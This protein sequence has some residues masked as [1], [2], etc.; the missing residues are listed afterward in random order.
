MR[1]SFVYIFGLLCSLL[2]ANGFGHT[3]RGALDNH[4]GP[5]EYGYLFV[6]NQTGDT[7]SYD[8]VELRGDPNA[9]WLDFGS[10]HENGLAAG[11]PLGM[12]FPFYGQYFETIL[13]GV[14]GAL[15][16]LTT[17]RNA[18]SQCIPSLAHDGPVIFPFGS[19]LDVD[20]GGN[21]IGNNST[22]AYRNFDSFTV[23][24]Y[25]SIGRCCNGSTSLK[26]E[27]ILYNSGKIKFQYAQLVGA[28]F[29]AI[30]IQAGSQGPA[31]QYGCGNQGHPP[32]EGLSI[33]FALDNGYAQ[34][35]AGFAGESAGTSVTLSWT[36]PIFDTNGNP[37]TPDSV[38]LY[39]D[40]IE[41]DAQI[42][43]VASGIQS[44]TAQNQ[45][46]GRYVY[47]ARAKAGD[48]VGL[49]AEVWVVIGVPSYQSDFESNSGGWNPG[50]VWEWGAPTNPNAPSPHSGSNVWAVGLN[51]DYTVGLCGEL[52][53]AP[54]LR[55]TSNL[56]RLDFWA[57]WDMGI[58]G[59]FQFDGVNLKS[60]VDD[61]VTWE[62]LSPEF[63]YRGFVL[64]ENLCIGSEAAWGEQSFGWQHIV[65]NVGHLFG[66]TPQFK[67]TFS[68]FGVDAREATG[69]FLDDVTLWGMSPE[70]SGIPATVENLSGTS[71]FFG[72]VSL[73]WD[74]PQ[75]DT[76]GNPLTPDTIL[77]YRGSAIPE[78][79]VANVSA[80]MEI[81]HFENQPFGYMPY[82]ARAKS[83]ANVGAPK[84]CWV[85]IG[86]PSYFSSFESDNGLWEADAEWEWGNPVNWNGPAPHSGENVWGVGLLDSYQ[87]GACGNIT[88]RP[89]RRVAYA[90]ATLELWFWRRIEAYMEGCV[91]QVSLNGG[92][93]WQKITPL[94]GYNGTVFGTPVCGF[95]GSAWQ[96]TD[97][98]PWQR[99]VFSLGQFV[100]LTPEFR[101]TF[102]ADPHPGT[103]TGV[104]VDDVSIWGLVP[105]EGIVGSVIETGNNNN[106]LAS[107]LVTSG[108]D[109][110]MTDHMGRYSIRLPVGEH[111]VLFHHPT[112][113]DTIVHGVF[114]EEEI[115]DTLNVSLL[116][117][118]ASISVS[119]LALLVRQDTLATESFF[120]RNNGDCALQFE[121][122]DTLEWLFA[123]PEQ[124]QIMP[125][126]TLE[127]SVTVDGRVLNVNDYE[128]SLWVT[129]NSAGSPIEI[130][131]FINVFSDGAYPVDLPIEFGLHGAFPNPFNQSARIAFD[132]PQA[133]H[134]S[135]Q[136]FNTLGQKVAT[137]CDAQ[138][139][140]G[141]HELI[142]DGY[143]SD[144]HD[145]ATG[146]YFCQIRAGSFS[147]T[148]KMVLMR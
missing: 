118:S 3:R 105:R 128:T 36:D 114:I 95:T 61:G 124:D 92:G 47:F 57:A 125:E 145:A 136:I 27:V 142:W 55:V 28:G 60:S 132:L 80:A 9:T 70:A 71:D 76:Y 41:P 2:S 17:N 139:L 127:I 148:K 30:G 78:S 22:I 122:N 131:V 45:P 11:I 104:Y 29:P 99:E 7:A 107:V 69:F 110:A 68:S 18:L 75:E 84:H 1:L 52:T 108:E 21:G 98:A 12:E 42:G 19:D 100:G 79:L 147:E 15:Q 8:W 14:N 73:Q 88:L 138:F 112:H 89:E 4:G 77:I 117:P 102:G 46:E 90:D 83:G 129:S 39:R 97:G 59:Q 32:V 38:L 24:E 35:V 141:R 66:Q 146:L 94:N 6:D 116:S 10:N 109:S 130:P 123:A 53:L 58:V 64:P 43:S 54:R 143:S 101:I 62:Q 20:Y 115:I 31:L 86:E 126:D 26:F 65:A 67:L 25:D 91:V 87:P 48:R 23:I 34:P 33:W 72:N 40:S 121:V 5:D 51:T 56:A 50:S 137:L 74:N 85:V 103:F 111:D 133:V 144:G 113:C 134:V 16:F 106:P 81:A 119:S 93:A 135:L 13:I 44:F 140:P 37:L 96:G 82:F 63:P 120:L 49:P